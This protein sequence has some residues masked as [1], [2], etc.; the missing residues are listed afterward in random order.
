MS[1]KKSNQKELQSRSGAGERAH[2]K[3]QAF[4]AHEKKST[5]TCKRNDTGQKTKQHTGKGGKK[6]KI[7]P[8]P[9]PHR[10]IRL[11][12]NRGAN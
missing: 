7:R 5:P 2:K 12:T 3:R 1:K 8:G 6:K 10:G 4:I 9:G 11:D